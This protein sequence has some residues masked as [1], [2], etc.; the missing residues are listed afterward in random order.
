MYKTVFKYELY[1]CTSTYSK[2]NKKC[3]T[4]KALCIDIC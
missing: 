1:I 3:L 2:L 4:M